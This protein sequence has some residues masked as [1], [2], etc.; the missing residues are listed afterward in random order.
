MSKPKGTYS[1]AV[2][3]AA[4][5]ERFAA[6]DP[7]A[8]ARSHEASFLRHMSQAREDFDW[9]VANEA[10]VHLGHETFADW[11]DVRVTPIAASLGMRPTREIAKTV[12][13]KV[14]EDQKDLPKAQQRSQ[15]EIAAMVGVSQKSVSRSLT[16]SNDSTAD[17]GEAATDPVDAMHAAL[18][19]IDAHLAGQAGQRT[20]DPTSEESDPVVPV[21]AS[22]A[23]PEFPGVDSGSAPAEQEEPASSPPADERPQGDAGVSTPAAAPQP[24]EDDPERVRLEMRERMTQRFCESLVNL[25]MA[26]GDDPVKWLEEIYLPGAYKMRDLPRVKDCFTPVSIKALAARIYAIGDHMH[27]TGLELR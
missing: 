16:E 20:E 12:I 15:R 2:L 5:A 13:E 4:A 14:F 7:A 1:G 23:L 22:S 6:Q 24:D 21:A 26:F 11:W 17:L 8:Q 10:W 25:S 27:E 3:R 9:I 19:D 18:E